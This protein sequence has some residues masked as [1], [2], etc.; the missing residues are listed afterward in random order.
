M[1]GWIMGETILIQGFSWLQGL[2]LLTGPLV[3]VGSWYLS[4]GVSRPRNSPRT[5]SVAPGSDTWS[6]ST[7]SNRSGGAKM[8]R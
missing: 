2:Y 4:H 3:A 5:C 8:R 6:L 1:V 7:E